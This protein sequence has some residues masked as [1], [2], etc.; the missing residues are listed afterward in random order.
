MTCLIIQHHV[1]YIQG[2]FPE[3]SEIEV[4]KLYLFWT[5]EDI[6]I[7]DHTRDNSGNEKNIME[8]AEE[9]LKELELRSLVDIEEEEEE[10]PTFTRFKPCRLSQ[11]IMPDICLVEGIKDSFVQLVHFESNDPF[12]FPNRDW[13]FWLIIK[14][15]SDI[16]GFPKSLICTKAKYLRC[17][18]TTNI[19]DENSNLLAFS[20]V[21]LNLSGFIVLRILVFRGVNFPVM[22]KLPEGISKLKRLRYLC[23]EGCHL[24]VLPEDIC[25]LPYFQILDL[26]VRHVIKIPNILQKHKKVE[27]FILAKNFPKLVSR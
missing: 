1:F 27:T 23:F 3:K 13:I 16:K 9:H 19:M 20:S 18:L 2:F 5:A 10:A 4:E 26:R 14:L 15:G 6:I 12:S 7:E 8:I 11:S 25:K 24:N 21:V 17:V 22:M